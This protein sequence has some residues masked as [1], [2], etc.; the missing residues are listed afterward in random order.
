MRKPLN[1]PAD[2]L[3]IKVI[4]D[5]KQPKHLIL[6]KQNA[7]DEKTYKQAR[8]DQEATTPRQTDIRY[9][10]HARFSSYTSFEF[11]SEEGEKKKVQMKEEAKRSSYLIHYPMNLK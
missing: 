4:N 6:I 5:N 9:R 11:D 2:G 10:K 7:M 8:T 3:E 1:R